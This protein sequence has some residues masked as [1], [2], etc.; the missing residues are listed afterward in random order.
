ME[1]S[2]VMQTTSFMI[3]HRCQAPSVPDSLAYPINNSIF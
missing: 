2:L 3:H 1:A